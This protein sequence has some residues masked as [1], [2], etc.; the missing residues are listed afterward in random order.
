MNSMDVFVTYI[1]THFQESL[2]MVLIVALFFKETLTEW[3][4]AK[5]GA[6][7]NE[8][9]RRTVQMANQMSELK[10][11]FN[12]ETTHILTDLQV[13]LREIGTQFQEFAKVQSTQCGK[14]DEMRDSLRDI[15]RN[16]IRIR[17]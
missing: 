10:M 13:G 8:T 1:T 12:D 14:L 2:I 16:G 15:V 4:K 9:E 11:H 3:V 17:K 5:M 6:A 7:P